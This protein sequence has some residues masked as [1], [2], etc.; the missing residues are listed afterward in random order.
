MTAIDTIPLNPQCLRNILQFLSELS[1]S[2]ESFSTVGP[3]V[4]Q[5]RKFLARRSMLDD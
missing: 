4:H 3:P 2:D 1:L 5:D